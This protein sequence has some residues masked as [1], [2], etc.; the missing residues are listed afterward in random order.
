MGPAELRNLNFFGW[1]FFTYEYINTET[2]DESCAHISHLLTW[3]SYVLRVHNFSII[4]QMIEIIIFGNNNS[5]IQNF[6]GNSARNSLSKINFLINQ[7]LLQYYYASTYNKVLDLEISRW[8]NKTNL[9][10]RWSIYHV[11][12]LTRKLKGIFHR[13][14]H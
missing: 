4:L 3:S 9:Q 10:G 11:D 2:G 7:R 13:V 8:T 6:S 14:I 12:H 5:D 1:K